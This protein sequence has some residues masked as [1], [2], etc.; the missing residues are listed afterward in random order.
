MNRSQKCAGR[1]QIVY[2]FGA[3]LGS[4]ARIDCNKAASY[5]WR[6]LLTEISEKIK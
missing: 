2:E 1:P 4:G 5:Q 3:G 6:S